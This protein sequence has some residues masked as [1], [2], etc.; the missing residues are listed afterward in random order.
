MMS[1]EEDQELED[2]IQDWHWDEKSHKFAQELGRYLFQFID[3][4]AQQG[5][6]E[7][8]VRKHADNCWCFGI[9]ECQYGYRDEFSP[10][11]VFNELDAPYENVFRRKVSDSR[12]AINSYRATWRKL[13]KYTKSLGYFEHEQS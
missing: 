6:S 4:L 8:T 13:Y 10:D 1:N 2:F 3:H 9:S 11:A 12:Y 7:Q 5:L